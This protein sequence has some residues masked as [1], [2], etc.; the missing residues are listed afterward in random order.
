[1]HQHQ[2]FPLIL[3]SSFGSAITFMFL[4]FLRLTVELDFSISVKWMKLNSLEKE[5]ELLAI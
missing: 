3:I 4:D 5:N 1:M 2:A